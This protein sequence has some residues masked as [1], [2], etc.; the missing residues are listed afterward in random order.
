MINLKSLIKWT[1]NILLILGILFLIFVLFVNGEL[2]KMYGGKT[3]E[4]TTPAYL[5]DPEEVIAIENVNVLS[6]NA[7]SIYYDKTVLIKQGKIEI[8]ADSLLITEGTAIIDGNGK[9]LIP[10]L[11]DQHI[12][13]WQSPNDLLLYIA[14]GITTVGELKGSDYHLRWRDEIEAGKRLGPHLFVTTTKIQ[15]K[16]FFAGAFLNWTQGDII[17]NN[18]Q[19]AKG[20]L[21]GLKK[22]GYDGVKIG[23]FLS[24]ECYIAINKAAEDLDW[25]VTGHIPLR[26]DLENVWASNQTNIAH[27]EEFVKHLNREF[28]YVHKDNKDEFLAHVEKRGEEIAQK[29]VASNISVTTTLWLM[30][31]FA[32]Q[33]KDIEAELASV[34]LKY[35][36]PGL[37]EGS[38][39][40]KGALGWLPNVNRY[41]PSSKLSEEEFFNDQAYWKT[42]AKANQ[43]LVRIF[44]EYS[45]EIIAG[46][47]ANVP[48]AV[49]GFSFHNELVSMSQQG[50][51]PSQVLRSATFKPAQW[52]KKNCGKIERGY[53][54]DL[55]L[56]N[57]NPLEDIRNT[58]KIE[59]VIL[60][61]KIF[62]RDQLDE[63]LEAVE[64]ANNETRRVRIDQYLSLENN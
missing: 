60:G 13:F 33:R 57:A 53:V 31:S 45:V 34:Q 30:E 62:Y 19:E 21:E 48:T 28:G 40:A 36:N 51:S 1:L 58:T 52:M 26:M 4:V 41:K 55:V 6:P 50:M 11:I 5:P 24:E 38:F 15:S 14:N 10:G 56:L 20:V 54:A 8:V 39:I 22:E 32:R 47:D 16:G 18:P 63:M 35:A 7:D 43:M 27:I 23:T 37:L 25:L 46:T 61:D 42:Y 49:P 3:K 29:L 59:T 17:L 2:K 9:Y 44:N 12:H 64:N